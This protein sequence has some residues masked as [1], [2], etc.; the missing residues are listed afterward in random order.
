MD[1]VNHIYLLC[2]GAKNIAILTGFQIA[3][4]CLG[5]ICR[6]VRVSRVFDLL[7]K[8]GYDGRLSW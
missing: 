6:S 4:D 7:P 2:S 8:G 3:S 5:D 1:R